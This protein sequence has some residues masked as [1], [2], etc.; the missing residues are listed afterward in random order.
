ML[1]DLGHLCTFFGLEGT[2][3]FILPQILAFLND[4]KDWYVQEF[5]FEPDSV[6]LSRFCSHDCNF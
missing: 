4:R 1:N 2:M 5:C 6:S 3:T